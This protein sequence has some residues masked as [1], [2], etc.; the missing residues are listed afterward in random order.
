[1]PDDR[2]IAFCSHGGS[3]PITVGRIEGVRDLAGRPKGAGVGIEGEPVDGT[4]K[5]S[6]RGGD[7]EIVLNSVEAVTE[8]GAGPTVESAERGSANPCVR[9]RS[10]RVGVDSALHGISAGETQKGRALKPPHT[11]GTGSRSPRHSDIPRLRLVCWKREAR[12]LE[13]LSRTVLGEDVRG[14]CARLTCERAHDQPFP[15][16]G[17][18]P[19]EEL[20][21]SGILRLEYRTLDEGS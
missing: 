9:E 11:D 18:P 16:V 6:A 5:I 1:M 21:L 10:I 14:A 7:P 17:K 13:P 2:E 12:L 15:V 19:S 8:K 4:F 3:E 20:A